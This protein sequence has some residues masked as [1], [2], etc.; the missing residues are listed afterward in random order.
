M[1]ALCF[2]TQVDFHVENAEP[3]LKNIFSHQ[4]HNSD[5]ESAAHNQKHETKR[6]RRKTDDSNKGEKEKC[7]SSTSSYLNQA[8]A[9]VRS[10][11]WL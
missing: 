3:L 10:L 1:H 9:M 7:L 11:W 5:G 2:P 4:T 8:R 6:T